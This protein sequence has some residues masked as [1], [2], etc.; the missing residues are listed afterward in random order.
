MNFEKREFILINLIWNVDSKHSKRNKAAVKIIFTVCLTGFWKRFR[1]L[2]SIFFSRYLKISKSR[3]FKQKNVHGDHA[4]SFFFFGKSELN[5]RFN[6]F[7]T[8][9]LNLFYPS[10]FSHEKLKNQYPR[11]TIIYV[12]YYIDSD[13]ECLNNLTIY[14]SG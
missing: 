13:F 7:I 1:V 8:F 12:L 3:N 14:S 5:L 9:K 10:Y 6:F 11:L 2:K 4:P